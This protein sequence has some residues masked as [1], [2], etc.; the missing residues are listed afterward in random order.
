MLFRSRRVEGSEWVAVTQ[1]ASCVFATQVIHVPQGKPRLQWVW[2][3]DN[4]DLAAA[5]AELK[6]AHSLRG[7]PLVGQLERTQYRVLSTEVPDVP[8]EEWRDAMRWRLKEQ[9][10]FPME[11]ALLEV[12]AVPQDTQL[13]QMFPA[14]ALVTQRADYVRLALAADD[15]GLNWSAIDTAETALRNLSAMAEIEG[16]AHALLVFGE[17]HGMLVITYQGELLM[18][19]NI[20]VA[21][22]AVTGS[23][24]ARGAALGRAALEVLRTLDTFERMH[25][26][27]TLSGL[28][29]VPPQGG[30]AD[31]LEVLADLVYVPTQYFSLADHLDMTALGAQADALAQGPSLQAL[32]AIGAALRAHSEALGRQS[33]NLLDERVALHPASSWSAMWAVWGVAGTVGVALLANLGLSMGTRYVDQRKEDIE[34][35]MTELRKVVVSPPPMP[36]VKELA[37]LRQ[38]DARQKQMRE[39]LQRTVSTAV[40]GYSDFLMALGRQAQGNLWITGLNL[41]DG[42]RDLELSGRMSDA[43]ALPVYLSRLQQEERFT[44]RRFA[45][46][47]LKSINLSQDGAGP[48]VLEFRLRSSV[49]DAGTKTRRGEMDPALKQ[50]AEQR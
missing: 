14:I 30:D 36:E 18:T 40:P 32:C 1:E 45:Q 17:T 46:V 29:V 38:T 4:A 31:V 50:L 19:R 15:V 24:E 2:Q 13:R 5:L 47:E 26:Q 7:L 23:N 16:Q 22:S 49:A 21:V 9:V 27:A 8:R 48:D 20:E 25:S 34:A 6:R 42:G 33:V 41:R 12:L 37:N 28:S 35:E 44:G 10:D 11:D 39:A 3:T 43:K